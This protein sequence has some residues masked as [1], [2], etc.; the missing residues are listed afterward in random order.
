MHTLG[1]M[2]SSL[3]HILKV[4]LCPHGPQRKCVK[5]DLFFIW[6]FGPMDNNL[7]HTQ[8][9]NLFPPWAVGKNASSIVKRHWPG[10]DSVVTKTMKTKSGDHREITHGMVL[11][12]HKVHKLHYFQIH[13][14]YLGN[15]RKILNNL[16]STK[17]VRFSTSFLSKDFYQFLT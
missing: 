1:P 2:D 7:T 17:F 14:L 6:S 5:Y 10:Y 12:P 4:F 13:S 8:S 16:T 3:T 15:F 9:M 11:K